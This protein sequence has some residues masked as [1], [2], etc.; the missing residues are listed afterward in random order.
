MLKFP[1]FC[2]Y[3][4]YKYFRANHDFFHFEFSISPNHAHVLFFLCFVLEWDN[5]G[6]NGFFTRSFVMSACCPLKC[7]SS[8]SLVVS[9]LALVV[10][11]HILNF[12]ALALSIY[13]LACL[14]LSSLVLT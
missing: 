7:A 13:C 2:L 14:V 11:L 5:H 9:H 4:C 1:L 8:L 12:L 3:K 10:L 6:M